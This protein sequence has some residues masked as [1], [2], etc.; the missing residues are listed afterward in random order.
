MRRMRSTPWR[1]A[2]I[3]A[4]AAVLILTGLGRADLFNPDEPREAEIA[5]EMWATRDLLVPRLNGEPFLEKP[6]LHYWLVMTAFRAAGGP[7]ETAARAVPAMAGILGVVLTWLFGRRLVGETA[8]AVGAL[9]LATSFEYWWI[10]RR[11]MIDVPLTLMVLVSCGALYLGMEERRRGRA[12]WLAVGYAAAAAAVLLKGLVGLGVPMVAVVA[13]LLLRRDPRGVLR[14]GLVPGALAALLPAAAWAWAL[15]DRLGE[16]A[17]REFAWVNNVER[18]IGGADGKG[19][20]QPLL[21][22]GREFLLDFA[23]WSLFLPFALVAAWRFLRR[24]SGSVP[25]T[26]GGRF[27]APEPAGVLFLLCW[28]VAPLLVLSLASTK[29]STYLLP[30]YPAAAL[31][32]GWLAAGEDEARRPL[33]RAALW[34]L[35]PGVLLLASIV[36]L[37]MLRVRPFDWMSPTVMVALLVPPGLVAWRAL[38]A[39]RTVPAA[40]AGAALAGVLCLGL[41]VGIVP[42]VVA[43]YASHRPAG[44]ALGRLAAAGDRI[45]LHDFGQGMLGELLFYAGRTFPNLRRVEDL[46]AHLSGPVPAIGPRP[47]ALVLES[48]HAGVVSRLRVPTIAARRFAHPEPPVGHPSESLV[49][50]VPRGG[51]GDNAGRRDPGRPPA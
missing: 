43:Q 28:F 14:H 40:L 20:Q 41:G 45:A 35:F 34:V 3:G 49:L 33:A 6:P 44:A 26:A 10:A 29:R 18:F 46:E 19:H 17:L 36:V 7:S 48:R 4:A 39:R 50:V 47:M 16:A 11:C 13:F 31:L 22:Y 9:V 8:A 37:V 23:P 51:I 25:G 32:C 21:Y 27:A 5:R 12:G 24:P 2:A 38:R 30:I 42:R 1:G 15:R